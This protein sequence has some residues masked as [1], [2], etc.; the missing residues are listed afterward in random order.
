M[1]YVSVLRIAAGSVG[2]T[3][4]GTLGYTWYMMNV[5]AETRFEDGIHLSKAKMVSAHDSI[6]FRKVTPFRT[7]SGIGEAG[8]AGRGVLILG[9]VSIGD[10]NR[11]N[12][13][14]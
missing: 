5:M 8:T 14:A 1:R 13:A 7:V 3:L 2:T 9:P 12:I 11:D 4:P 6:N 10:R